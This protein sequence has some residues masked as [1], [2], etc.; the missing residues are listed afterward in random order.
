MSDAPLPRTLVVLG[1][2]LRPLTE[3]LQTRL[4]TPIPQT[5]VL[6]DI[7]ALA[8]E[9]LPQF[10]D[11]CMQLPRV[12][13]EG[14]GQVASEA[15]APDTVVYR[16]VGRLE[17]RVEQI[18]DRYDEVRCLRASAEDYWG[19]HL[20]GEIYR[21]VLGQIQGWLDE[22]VDF[23]GDPTAFLKKHDIAPHGDVQV[24]F[25]LDLSAPPEVDQL[26]TWAD[27]RADEVIAGIE[28]AREPEEQRVGVGGLLM[29]ALFGWWLGGG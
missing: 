29:A 7:F 20:L 15:D 8:E 6:S 22:L 26:A 27:R 1:E 2:A 28:A 19:W 5:R 4:N 23:L 12:I 3:E 14:I 13:S 21:D 9:H 11:D 18:L 17:V 10:A 25:S 16:A 24:N